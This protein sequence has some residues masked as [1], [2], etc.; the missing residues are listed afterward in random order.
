MQNSH[1]MPPTLSPSEEMLLNVE[2]DWNQELQSPTFKVELMTKQPKPIN[3]KRSHASFLESLVAEPPPISPS[4]RPRYCSESVDNFVTHWLESTSDAASASHRRT[5]CRSDSFLDSSNVDYI[6]RRL[7][8]S[9]SNMPYTEEDMS[10]SVPKRENDGF[11]L[12]PTPSLYSSSNPAS[13]RNSVSMSTPASSRRSLV[14]DP[15]YRVNNLST[16]HIFLQNSY[17][18]NFQNTST[19]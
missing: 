13:A 7:A 16:N 15:F 11:I 10:S 17:L 18:S 9:I 3:P 1:Q 4:K 12:P 2:G 8:K 5:Y 6:P 19:D 14:D